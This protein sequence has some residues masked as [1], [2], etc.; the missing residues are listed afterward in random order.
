MIFGRTNPNSRDKSKPVTCA[1]VELI[2]T[3]EATDATC[4]A[5]IEP[6]ASGPDAGGT[7]A[8]PNGSQQN[9]NIE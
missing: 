5:E 1:A 7:L 3:K 8:A 2:W 4:F 6:V 9:A